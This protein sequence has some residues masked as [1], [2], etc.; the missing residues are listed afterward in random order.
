MHTF[1]Y[2]ANHKEDEAYMHRMCA[3][4]WAAVR[5]VEGFWTFEPCE[6]GEFRYRVCYLRGMNRDRVEE[7]KRK[8][9]EK[10]VEFV[11]RYSFWAIFRSREEFRLYTPEEDREICRKIYAPMPVGAA[12]SWVL[13]LAAAVAACLI[14]PFFW[15]PAVLLGLYGAMCTWLGL[16]YRKLLKQL[17]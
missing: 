14:S 2:C 3:K 13:F 12:V 5:L 15:I 1:Q 16:S 6:P 8:Y 17:P 7:L 10:G 11:S 4:G 9:A